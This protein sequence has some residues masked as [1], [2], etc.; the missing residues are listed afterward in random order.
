M[1]MEDA[2]RYLENVSNK[3]VVRDNLSFIALYVGL[4]ESFIHSIVDR[5]EG[6]LS[7]DFEKGKR[8]KTKYIHSG[9]Y[10]R[11]IKE[12]KVDSSGN[13]DVTK[14]TV[15]WFVDQHAIKQTDY[16]TFLDLKHRRNSYA[17]EIG[18]IALEGLQEDAVEA[19]IKLLTLYQKIDKWWINEIEIPLT[20]NVPTGYA[21]EGVRNMELAQ[22]EVMIYALYHDSLR[23]IE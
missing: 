18:R 13:R 21:H 23:S 16:E 9:E 4:Y 14:A 10:K 17:H 12:R 1:T 8:G 22:F 2:K 20:M 5:V 3:E 15:L 6:F 11:L 19:L 7:D